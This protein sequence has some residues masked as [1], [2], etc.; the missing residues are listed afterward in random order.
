MKPIQRLRKK[1]SHEVSMPVQAEG[2]P[3]D[4]LHRRMDDLFEDFFEQF[5]HP[6]N[7]MPHSLF[8]DAAFNP[9][10]EVSDDEKEF[11]I[12]AE[13]PG[14]NEEDIQVQLDEQVLI[15]SGEKREERS[16][17]KKHQHYSEVQYGSFQRVIP[18]PQAV[19]GTQTQA[20][21]KRGVLTVRLPKTEAVRSSARRIEIAT[22][23]Q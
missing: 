11:V 12:K 19:D 15:V 5:E 23:H 20:T 3:F 14:M 13:L 10:F 1:K 21:F 17:R 2:R 8:G 16:K 9:R 22:T 18:L 7:L 4:L 6:R